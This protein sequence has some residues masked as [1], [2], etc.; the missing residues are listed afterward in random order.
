PAGEAHGQPLPDARC[1]ARGEA[2]LAA[3]PADA[4]EAQAGRDARR[5]LAGVALAALTLLAAVGVAAID[6]TGRRMA[7]DLVARVLRAGLPAGVEVLRRAAGQAARPA[8]VGLDRPDVAVAGR[9]AH[10]GDLIAVRRPDGVG[11][12]ARVAGER[13]ARDGGRV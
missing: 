6:R 10:E 9:G 11:V 1:G 5:R 12:A 2:D 3:V 4:A 7:A 8:A 13:I